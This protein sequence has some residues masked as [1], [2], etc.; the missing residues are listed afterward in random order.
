MP[1]THLTVQ[2]YKKDLDPLYLAL[3]LSYEFE[4]RSRNIIQDAGS[5]KTG[6]TK[7]CWKNIIHFTVFFTHKW[8]GYLCFNGNM[9][10]II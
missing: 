5:V 7:M 4:L 9:K 2:F 3:F 1:S 10:N 6:T 8:F